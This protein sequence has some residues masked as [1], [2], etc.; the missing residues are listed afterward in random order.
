MPQIIPIRDLR[1]TTRIS[2]LCHESN[3]PIY[4]TKNGYGD[5]VILSMEAYENMFS[6]L[7]MYDAVMAGKEQ[8]D[9][10]E[11]IDGEEAMQKMREN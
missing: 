5:M 2:N 4:I 9:K 3:E 10:G 1:D 8:A 11:L 7:K 6:R